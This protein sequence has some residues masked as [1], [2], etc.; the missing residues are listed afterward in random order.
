MKEG[1]EKEVMGRK[2]ENKGRQR[3]RERR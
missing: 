1:S 2:R 3:R